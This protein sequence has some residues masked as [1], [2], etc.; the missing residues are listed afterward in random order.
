M[1]DKPQG[2]AHLI[3]EIDK[4]KR[5]LAAAIEALKIANA[6]A[7]DQMFLKREAQ[8]QRDKAVVALKHYGQH[9]DGCVDNEGVDCICGYATAMKECGN[10]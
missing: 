2:Y 4:I 1:K 5:E 3:A 6:S 8:A 9:V 7:D 10:E